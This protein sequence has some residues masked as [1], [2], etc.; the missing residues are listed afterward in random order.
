MTATV[1]ESPNAQRGWRESGERALRRLSATTLAGALLGLLV[2]G[3]GGRLA[4]MLLARLNP[5]AT[6]ITSDDGF[7]IGQFT[8]GATLQLLL[9]GTFF[10]L[11]GACVY[12]LVRHL[13]VGP[14]WFEVL[15]IS[16]GPAV[17]VGAAIVH[18]DGVDFR[19]LEP[20]WLAIA[21]FLAIPALYAA[22]LTVVAERWL[23]KDGWAARASLPL[24]VIPLVLL[25]PLAPLV[26][27]MV[28]LW[29]LGE[30]LRRH[31]G[32]RG[33][34][35]HPALP[36]VARLGLVAVFAVALVDLTKD[37]TELAGSS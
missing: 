26:A 9:T 28:A 12:A 17:V 33:V 22:L 35:G 34:V 1:E 30:G 2:G 11:L 10:G 3:V 13:M 21:L 16:G 6:G 7:R 14:R 37:V 36:W 18:S 24:S 23:R 20:A 27:V 31:S 15:S 19:A 32:L 5:D 29:A 8:V 4:M 25:I